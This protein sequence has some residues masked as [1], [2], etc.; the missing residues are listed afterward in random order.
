MTGGPGD[1]G[2]HMVLTWAKRPLALPRLAAWRCRLSRDMRL[3]ARTPGPT[4]HPP[5]PS[6]RQEHLRAC[7][8]DHALTRAIHHFILTCS[9][10]KQM[11]PLGDYFF[12]V[13]LCRQTTCC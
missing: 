1:R 8:G 11:G 12:Q 3:T 4:A 6:G 2:L 7:A 13:P 10:G 9:A 5:R